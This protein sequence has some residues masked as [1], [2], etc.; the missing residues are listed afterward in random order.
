MFRLEPGARVRNVGTGG[1]RHC[2]YTYFYF[3]L[4]TMSNSL[5]VRLEEALE[6]LFAEGGEDSQ[7]YT[8]LV[9]ALCY[10]RG[11]HHDA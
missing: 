7:E 5:I 1:V 6:E 2:L 4:N 3:G 8:L 9:D 11:E 10:I